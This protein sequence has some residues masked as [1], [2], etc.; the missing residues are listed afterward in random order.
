MSLNQVKKYNFSVD[1]KPIVAAS[2]SLSG[3]SPLKLL[4]FLIECYNY[5]LLLT[6][7]LQAEFYEVLSFF[8]F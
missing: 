3:I 8:F 6:A 1:K 2:Y 7:V 4:S 5:I